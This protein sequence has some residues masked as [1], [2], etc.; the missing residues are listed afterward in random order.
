MRISRALLVVALV[1][2]GAA[3]LTG[4]PIGTPPDDERDAGPDD[5][6]YPAP[7][8]DLTDALGDD[9]TLDLAAWNLK[10]FPCG[11][12]SYSTVCRDDQAGSVE[13]VTD[14]IAS[15][16]LDVL[17]VEEIGDVE[18]FEEIV[19][20]LPDHEGVLS[21]DEY[22]DGTYQ[23]IG[24]IYDATLLE[25]GEPV[26]LFASSDDFPRPAFQVELTWTGPGDP[27]TFLVIA[28]HLKAGETSADRA[29][30]T[31]AV[32]QLE[33][34]VG[35]LVDGAGQDNVIVLGDFNETLD[36]EGGPVFQPLRD[37]A[38]YTIQ[39]QTNYDAGEETFLASGA[40]LD[41]IVTTAALAGAIGGAHSQIPRLQYDVDD[42][43]ARVSDHL[44]VALS[45]ANP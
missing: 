20:R 38:R 6:G 23:K 16:A 29:E 14:L 27:L 30:R 45:L 10:N 18:A 15:L 34:Y 24:V 33:Q 37:G 17:A 11:N 12:E 26:A 43:R 5:T 9:D 25:A 1:V 32:A 36:A 40:I 42:Y 35:N 22:F 3:A 28:L 19:Q 8:T 31:R 39:T 21:T 41:H 44:P 13:L 2:D 4:C 7:R